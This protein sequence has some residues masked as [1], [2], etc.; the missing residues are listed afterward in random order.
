MPNFQL[1][2]NGRYAPWFQEN[3]STRSLVVTQFENCGVSQLSALYD[4]RQCSSLD[5][6]GGHFLRLRAA[7]LALRGPPLQMKLSHH[8]TI[9]DL[10]FIQWQRCLERELGIEV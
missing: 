4:R 2:K 1:S 8:R 9:G 5:I 10:A 6:A 7:A 3:N